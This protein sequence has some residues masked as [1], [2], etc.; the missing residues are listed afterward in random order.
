MVNTL[1]NLGWFASDALALLMYAD[2]TGDQ[3]DW[4]ES[5]WDE[6]LYHFQQI[7][8]LAIDLENK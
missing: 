8:P 2:A 3:P 5:D 4:S 7:E 6:L 1:L